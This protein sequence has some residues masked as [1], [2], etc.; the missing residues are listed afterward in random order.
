[1]I[2]IDTMDQQIYYGD[3]NPKDLADALTAQ[4]NRGNLRTQIVGDRDNLKV[5]IATRRDSVSGGQTAL[6]VSLKKVPDGVMV[7]I[8]SQAWL[9]VAASLGQSALA[10]LLNPMNLLGRLD[11][12]A[13]DIENMQ[14]ADGVWA[15]LEKAARAHGASKQVASRL[16]RM[17][18]EYCNTANPTGTGSCV[19]CGAPLGN[20]Q[21]RT[22]PSCGFVVLRGEKNCPNCTRQ[23]L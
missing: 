18:C 12:I 10:T 2:I 23:I 22:C 6:T 8:G 19:A 4:Y 20:V 11:D 7:Q 15:A 1:M 16:R 5:Q 13:Q 3:L 9:G 17:V 14:L 21:P